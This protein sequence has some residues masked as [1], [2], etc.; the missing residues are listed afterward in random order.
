[1]NNQTC[2]HNGIAP[3]NLIDCL[4]KLDI[5]EEYNQCPI[6]AYE[7][8]YLVGSSKKWISF[9]EYY[10]FSNN[11]IICKNGSAISESDLNIIKHNQT[12]F[13]ENNCI[14]CAFKL[15]FE[16]GNIEP[17]FTS[18]YLKEVTPPSKINFIYDEN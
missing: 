12:S 11:K 6:C 1:M 3:N 7:L 15:G 8:G 16:S 4:H 18:I 5:N 2:I 13:I 14:V 10:E 9:N 17:N